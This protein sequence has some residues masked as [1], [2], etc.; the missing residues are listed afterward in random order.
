MADEQKFYKQSTLPN[1]TKEIKTLSP[2]PE[3]IGPYK[4]DSLLRKGGMSLL[5]LGVHPEK[6]LSLVIKVLSPNYMT[7]P[8]MVG[9]FL[10]E[11]Q[12][13]S[14]TDHPNIVKL[15]GQGRWENG[16]YIAMEFIQGVS[17]KQFITKQTLSSSS[18]LE[19]LLQVAYALLHLHAHGVVHRDLKPENI[20]VNENGQ[21]KVIDFGISQLTFDHEKIHLRK[22]GQM[23]G[24]PSYMSPEQQKDPLHVTGAADIY[25][26]GVIAY[27]LLLGKLSYGSIQTSL[28]PKG[29]RKIV[30]KALAPSLEK[31]YL[32][33]VDLIADISEY[34][35]KEHDV[36]ASS[37]K[38]GFQEVWGRMDEGYHLLFPEAPPKWN[39]FDFGFAKSKTHFSLSSFHTF[40]R[41]ADG[42]F[43]VSIGEVAQNELPALIYVSLLKGMIQTLIDPYLGTQDKSFQPIPFI[44]TLNKMLSPYEKKILFAFHLLYLTPNKEQF[45]LISCG[46]KSLLHFTPG[47]SKPRFI[48]NQN[49]LLG[50]SP[51]YSFYETIENWN[52]GDLLLI[53][54]FNTS[55][56]EEKHIE[57]FEGKLEALTAKHLQLSAQSQ[58][59]TILSDLLEAGNVPPDSTTKILL[60]V[61]R[62]T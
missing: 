48:A 35:K 10:K 31:R 16:L 43:F 12:I 58:A 57:G 26:F 24:T 2:L 39:R 13:I 38:G 61:Q 4:I 46:T 1:L 3:K 30:E 45:S 8:E 23:I 36:G 44:T 22:K 6:Q 20:L 21:V 52:V 50:S 27:E 29:L 41:F 37:H 62:I 33:V 56:K 34:L 54:T 32:D 59:A 11:A 49:P 60:T 18:A 28:L 19:I 15:Y 7:H 51:N 53:H 14:I 40:H 55:I 17:L 42:T 9:Q 25:S 5:Y 47:I